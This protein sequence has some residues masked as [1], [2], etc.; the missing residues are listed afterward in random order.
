MGQGAAG[1]SPGTQPVLL[2][3]GSPMGA[4]GFVAP[5]GHFT[6]RTVAT[7]DPAERGAASAPTAPR[8]PPSRSRPT[9]CTG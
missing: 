3:I 1:A 6:D 7:Y 2:L 9:I 5:A 8:R 4:E